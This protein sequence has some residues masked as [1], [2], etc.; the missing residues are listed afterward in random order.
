LTVCHQDAIWSCLRGGCACSCRRGRGV[1]GMCF[2]SSSTRRCAGCVDPRADIG[3]RGDHNVR[4]D[5]SRPASAIGWGSTRQEF[6][7]VDYEMYELGDVQLSTGQ[8]LRDAKLAYKTYG[9]LNEDKSNAIVYPTWYSGQHYDN[10][11]LIGEGMA[12]DPSKY[13]IIIPLIFLS[14]FDAPALA[15]WAILF[16]PES[17][18]FLTVGLPRRSTARTPTGFPRSACARHDRGGC[19]LCPGAAVFT[20]PVRCPR[21]PPAA[22]QRPALHPGRTSRRPGLTLTRRHRRVRSRSPVRSSPH[23]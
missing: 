19:P 17:W 8:T 14:P 10:E 23:L 1:A 9:T 7:M 4:F 20:R 6:H 12:L 16:P 13:F 2:E 11:W 21:P 22:S 15:S 3:R 18:A 5:P